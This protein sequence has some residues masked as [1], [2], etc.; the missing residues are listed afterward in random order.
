M[1]Q[2]SAFQRSRLIVAAL[3]IAL[4]GVVGT[5][6]AALAQD[7][8][9]TLRDGRQ[10]LVLD[11]ATP[12]DTTN[13]LNLVGRTGGV[14]VSPDGATTYVIE[15]ANVRVIAG[16]VLDPTPIVLNGSPEQLAVSPDG[17]K[18]YVT[19]FGNNAKVH[20]IDV[21]G[22]NAVSVINFNVGDGAWGIAMAATASGDFGYVTLGGFSSTANVVKVFDVSAG[23]IVATVPVG[24]APRGVAASPLGDRVYV[25]NSS[26]DTVS[27][28]DTATNAVIATIPVGDAPQELTVSADGA[29]VYVSLR[30]AGAVDV[31][32]TSTN[33][34]VDTIALGGAGEELYG[35][36]FSADG[37]YVVV[38]HFGTD[39]VSVIDPAAGNTFISTAPTDVLDAPRYVAFKPLTPLFP[40]DPD[41]AP[42]FN[43][44]LC[45]AEIDAVL[46][47]ELSIPLS[48]VDDNGVVVSLRQSPATGGALDPALP[49]AP[50]TSV[51]S[52]FLWTPGDDDAGDYGLEFTA[53]DGVNEPVSCAVTVRVPE[54]PSADATGLADFRLLLAQINTRGYFAD[55]FWFR[56]YFTVDRDNG[57]DIAPA[58]EDVTINV[59][60]QQWTIPASE[61]SSRPR[62]RQFMYRGV[63]D[64]T[65]LRV[66]I[67]PRGRPGAGRYNI[68]VTGWKSDMVGADNPLQMCVTI[69]DDTGCAE[70]RGWIR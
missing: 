67:S 50:S 3:V 35:I 44:P 53:D 27:V 4:A 63:V 66:S 13:R 57:N 45:D 41:T 15:E 40:P 46:G 60:G 30:V 21:A 29:L 69:G 9:I 39:R 8:Y 1:G 42:L 17:S 58:A 2:L 6:T 16:G 22:G 31:I 64:G 55:T 14:A 70:R 12:S 5:T 51:E 59:E 56:G 24:V 18:V 34:V 48:V 33:A 54:L 20:I 32:D 68:N 11:P 10:V 25:A 19:N 52:S 49:S 65:R 61:F 36:S 47:S 7:G 28:I 43:L 23:T 38:A 62:T 37:A 26:G